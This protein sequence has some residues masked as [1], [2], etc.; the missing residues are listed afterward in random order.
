MAGVT[1]YHQMADQHMSSELLLSGVPDSIAARKSPEQIV[2]QVFDKL[3]VANLTSDILNIREF[4][5]KK[6]QGGSNQKQSSR[7]FILHLKSSD[8][9]HHIIDR[10]RHSPK[11]EIKNIFESSSNAASG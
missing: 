1:T 10:K 11:L 2:H 5:A 6:K 4:N 7:S 8:V 9:C 3:G